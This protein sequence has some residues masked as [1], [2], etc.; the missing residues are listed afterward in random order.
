MNKN[1]T[2]FELLKR[3]KNQVQIILM[4]EKIET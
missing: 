3:R 2:D 4:K 1:I